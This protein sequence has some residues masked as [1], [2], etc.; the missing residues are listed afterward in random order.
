MATNRLQAEFIHPGVAHSAESIAFVKAKIEA[1]EQPWAK[2]WQ[3]G[4]L[5]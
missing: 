3:D 4:Y 1:K 5:P 2:A